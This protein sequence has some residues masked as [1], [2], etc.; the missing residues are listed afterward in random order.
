MLN[1]DEMSIVNQVTDWMS[2]FM[3]LC[4]DSRNSAH[5]PKPNE[6]FIGYHQD[7]IATIILFL[8]KGNYDKLDKI[9]DFTLSQVDD[10]E[11][12]IKKAKSI[13]LRCATADSIVR[14]TLNKQNTLKNE[15]LW[16]EY[17]LNQNHLC[18]N[19]LV[20]NHVSNFIQNSSNEAMSLNKSLL[21]ITT[22]SKV[23]MSKASLDQLAQHLGMGDLEQNFS[24][25][26]LQSFETQQQF[27]LKVRTFLNSG[28]GNMAE[29]GDT[30]RLLV[31][32]CDFGKK[33]DA[34]LL[35][36]ARYTIVEQLKEFHNSETISNSKNFILLLV[37]LAKE[38]SKKFIGF[39]VG[40]WT[41]Y[42][43]D[44][45]VDTSTNY[46]PSLESM[47]TKSLSELLNQ[48]LDKMVNQE[49]ETQLD[50]CMNLKH[51]LKKMAH[52]SCSLIFDTNLTRTIQRIEIFIRL[53]DDMNFVRIVAKRLIDL[54]KDKE[55][56]FMV[57]NWLSR[58]VAD[59]KSINEYSTLKRSCE[60]YIE[61]KLSPLLAFLLAKIDHF[62]NLDLYMQD[63]IEWKR[64]LFLNVLEKNEFF[65]VHY[66]E[67]RETTSNEEL[68]QFVCKSDR[69]K[70][71]IQERAVNSLRPSL[72]FSW[73]LV[74]ELNDFCKNF[75]ESS[76]NFDS[77]NFLRTIPD[78]FENKPIYKAF[79]SIVLLHNINESDLLELYIND[80][81]LLSCEHMKLS[82]EIVIIKHV[83]KMLINERRSQFM[84]LSSLKFS[85]PLVHFVFE[86]F[87]AKLDVYLSFSTINPEIN[88]DLEKKLN[89]SV[90][91]DLDSCLAAIGL[92]EKPKLAIANYGE[93]KKSLDV[94]V[95]AVRNNLGTFMNNEAYANNTASSEKLNQIVSKY[96]ALRFFSL[97]L[98][99]VVLKA[100]AYKFENMNEKL[101]NLLINR[102]KVDFFK[103]TVFDFSSSQYIECVHTFLTVCVLNA[104][105]C[106]FNQY[107]EA[108]CCGKEC[109]A[110]MKKVISNVCECLV[111]P[112]C[113]QVMRTHMARNKTVCLG[114]KREIECFGELSKSLSEIEER[115]S[116]FENLELNLNTFYM[117]T[118]ETL[119][120]RKDA[121]S[122][123]TKLVESVLNVVTKGFVLGE[124][125]VK[126]MIKPIYKSLLIQILY[127]NYNNAVCEKLN[128]TFRKEEGCKEL[129]L[130][131]QDCIQTLCFK[132]VANKDLNLKIIYANE[133]AE[134][135]IQKL[136]LLDEIFDNTTKFYHVDCL[137][138]LAKFKYCLKVIAS[139]ASDPDA[140]HL[141]DEVLF[142]KFNSNMKT[143]MEP[144][145]H[146]YKNDT[147]YNYLI[148]EIIRKYSNSAIKHILGEEN[149]KWMVPKE[150]VGDDLTV[151]DRYILVGRSYT[152]LK[153]AI[154]ECFV[155]QDGTPL[156][157]ELTNK[158]IDNLYPYVMLAIYK[159]ITLVYKDIVNVPIHF[160]IPVLAKHYPRQK[161]DWQPMIE[162]KLTHNLLINKDNWKH[163][164]MSLLL[165]QLKTFI[166]SSK[167]KLV[168]PL[169]ELIQRPLTFNQSYLPCMP[170]DSMF[171]IQNAIRAA[172]TG[173]E[174]P[175]FY[176]CPNGHPYVLFDCGRPWQTYTCK[177]CGAE[178]G[179]TQH[180]LLPT[181]RRIE[182][183]DNTLK[184]HCLLN[185]NTLA[186]NPVNERELNPQ[187]FHIL[188]FFIH[189]C[190][191]FSSE[192]A[193]IS[194]LMVVN[195]EDKKQFFW[196]HMLKDLKITSRS[197]NITQDETLIL[198]HFIV[199]NLKTSVVDAPG[200]QDIKWVTKQERQDW[201][202]KFA[203]YFLDQYLKKTSEYVNKATKL[204]KDEDE[205]KK[206]DNQC[207]KLYF[208][209][210][211]LNSEDPA[212]EKHIYENSD[213][214]KYQPIVSL[215]LLRR[216]LSTSTEKEEFSLL[217]KFIEMQDYLSL[218]PSMSDIVR[219]VNYLQS[220]FY[221][222]IFRHFSAETTLKSALEQ[223]LFSKEWT[224]QSVERVL[225]S[226]QR[227]W[228][229]SKQFLNNYINSNI[230]SGLALKVTNNFEFSLDT[231]LSF[232]LPTL[233]GDGL[234]CYSMMHYLS[235]LHNEMLDF[236]H[237][238]K[239]VTSE[240]IDVSLFENK[241]HVITFEENSDLLRIIHYNFTYDSKAYKCIFNYENI[242]NQI[243]ERYLQ[244][245]QLIDMKTLPLF[246]YSDEINDQTL[247]TKLNQ[248]IKQDLIDLIIQSNIFNEFKT[249]NQTAEMLNILKIVI[250][251]AKTTMPSPN[252]NLSDYMRKIYIDSALNTSAT[253][254]LAQSLTIVGACQMN[255]LKH[256]WTLLKM[257]KAFLYTMNNLD[258][259]ESLN[260]K[261]K[262]S[263]AGSELEL[264]VS[265]S[266]TQILSLAFVIYQLIEHYCRNDNEFDT[267]STNKIRDYFFDL[268]SLNITVPIDEQK[269]C[270]MIHEEI[271]MKSIY[272]LWVKICDLMKKFE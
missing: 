50:V 26:L 176:Q 205:N 143:L 204:L 203:K 239:R 137:K 231:K 27:A 236:Y 248:V 125:N 199:D 244:T 174:N 46:L 127:R 60:N 117:N 260:N 34:D 102:L 212:K 155:K 64:E 120:F 38:S 141:A 28:N 103:R 124:R 48:G 220:S 24:S 76:R 128:Q 131:F 21:Q 79:S 83:L 75:L 36:C 25:C 167:S 84:H 213:F 232:F 74:N 262:D 157:N 4:V 66:D 222:L 31:I 123:D 162:N 177:V 171:D 33:Y 109:L 88:I 250:N 191:Y 234:L 185:A 62:S 271:K 98:D 56:K 198:L 263:S 233:N 57:S 8:T 100:R 55:S 228:M 209:A 261:L 150:L 90:T 97:F 94:L 183:T 221:K 197:L 251:Y 107:K 211:E 126:L 249:I 144:T 160:F 210:Y 201:E 158:N 67:M 118:I 257:K 121:A 151:S 142:N 99:N 225:E 140:M 253:S 101:F 113:D 238:I 105:R 116:T 206:E 133:M 229:Y 61:S 73:I 20:L 163:V 5:K 112:D 217:K 246:E 78:L 224:E 130:L 119:V 173:R 22:H 148:K 18:L 164:E 14:L 63:V 53:C 10:P 226:F 42:H 9:D 44:E 169:A 192:Y 187:T 134:E 242:T 89:S 35:S 108:S 218:L 37:T 70:K 254:D 156:N 194:G 2:T 135:L 153:T 265:P 110:P 243:V 71:S 168:K 77:D 111:C 252:M 1:A 256:L 92:F 259:F 32:Q 104:R 195:P 40:H 215:D 175:T 87:K 43:I 6:V 268:E 161:F 82:E 122:P 47:K 182:V 227:V 178:I 266:P 72:P 96:N 19:D 269:L 114:C 12:L 267:I 202:S 115:K 13:L 85:L 223:N 200:N 190:L 39:Q 154:D 230:S 11:S 255:H 207:K 17:F 59:L 129:A 138:L 193:D 132:N 149:I 245:K 146:H 189:A 52:Q 68:K 240:S 258:P 264:L 188:R 95:K 166:V 172:T 235:K 145:L 241:E 29:S 147:L 152:Q 69:F 23:L 51:L 219:L 65:Q 159:N 45:L 7:T 3:K 247:L 93:M 86:K 49:K 272:Q 58:E 180:N 208:M 91:I 106:L 170:Q 80:F 237:K 196:D 165:V 216:E 54:Q 16:D 15:N 186:D 179:G 30:A 270:E 136:G 214:W 41:C 181:N 81:V 139:V 184:G